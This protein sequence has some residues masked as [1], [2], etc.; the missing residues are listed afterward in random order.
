M[1]RIDAEPRRK[2]LAGT[3]LGGTLLLSG[4]GGGWG[5]APAT[6][7]Q[8]R[9]ERDTAVA[10]LLAG[11]PVSDGRVDPA[12]S[13]S[14]ITEAPLAATAALALVPLAVD[15]GMR[16]ISDTVARIQEERSALWRAG[17]LGTLPSNDG[18]C[19][20][21]M[22]GRVGSLPTPGSV[23]PAWARLPE[24]SALPAATLATRLGFLAP[25]DFYMEARLAV[26]Q[27]QAAVRGRPATP[28]QLTLRP[29][30]L[31][32]ARTA[33]QRDRDGEKNV[34]MVVALRAAPTD[35]ATRPGVVDGASGV[36]VLDFGRIEPGTEILPRRED[37]AASPPTLSHPFANLAQTITLPAGTAP[38]TNMVALVAETAEPNRALAF[39]AEALKENGP[40][41]ETTLVKVIQDALAARQSPAR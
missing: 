28:T 14:S 20:V 26:E 30:V 21:V 40:T 1:T 18:G 13:P 38:R 10:M 3:L 23:P 15:F 17:G 27:G 6:G 2:R 31:H 16:W 36:F 34:V 5:G 7:F 22:R 8:V 11:C 29:Q 39:L 4:C 12:V 37:M 33:A 41:L 25:P 19:L 35:A 9:H 32:F 24:T